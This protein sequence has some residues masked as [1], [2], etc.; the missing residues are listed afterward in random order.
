MIDQINT[1]DPN[2]LG[3]LKRLANDKSPEAIKKVAEQFEAIFMQIVLKS[4][5]DATPSDGLFD[6]D[7]TRFYDELH[8]QQL[9][10][11]MAE[12][13]GLGLAAVLE[14]QLSEQAS[15]Q[16]A[17]YNLK[18][19]PMTSGSTAPPASE[20]AMATNEPPSD[21]TSQ[22]VAAQTNDA[23]TQNFVTELWPQAAE[24]ARSLGVP[25]HFLIGQAALESGW[26]TAEMRT[27]DGRSSHN[28]FNIKAGKGWK[29]KVVEV[30]TTEYENG[31]PQNRIERFRAYDSYAE[32]FQ[33]YARLIRQ[34]PR[35][36]EALGQTD[37]KGFA[38]ALQNG[39]YA[40]DP[41][42]ADK[43]ARIINGNSLRENLIASS[44]V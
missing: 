12:R 21:V 1:L 32:G 29:G 42:Y 23:K 18:S 37:A 16:P 27:R 7:S 40:T 14:K 2:S 10:S 15:P 20:S 9:A 34:S 44:G 17:T 5:R 4:M 25:T 24:A 13:G 31:V 38:R 39:G 19:A 26:G 11:V 41:A 36:A 30:M 3:D 28:L 33:D 8:D 35:Y 6:S 43:L 22:S